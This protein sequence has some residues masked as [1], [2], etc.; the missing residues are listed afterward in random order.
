MHKKLLILLLFNSLKTFGQDL[1]LN[2]NTGLISI[3]DSVEVKKVS[4]SEIKRF[5]SM[6][7]K[8]YFLDK[9]TRENLYKLNHKE[10]SINV[11]GSY[12]ASVSERQRN[13][14]HTSGHLSYYGY[15]RGA[16]TG[17]L[18]SINITSGTV[19]FS[20]LYT[21]KNDKL[22]V[23]EITNFEFVS[24][25]SKGVYG[26]FEDSKPS[27]PFAVGI[28]IKN[29]KIW[30]QIKYDYFERLKI[31]SKGFKEYTHNYFNNSEN[32]TIIQPVKP[33]VNYELYKRI[34]INMN[35]NQVKE[36]FSED[37]KELNTTMVNLNGRSVAQKI[38]VWPESNSSSNRSITVIFHDNKVYS[39]SQ[40]GL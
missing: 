19:S 15:K 9:N 8:K 21:V 28:L 2:P 38:C 12:F 14:F 39:K 37:G 32:S 30:D 22:L 13:L 34:E 29:K 3:I 5:L 6:N 24:I 11:D 4:V 7:W 18:N 20:F 31:M 26:K 25:A 40:T 27:K 17:E 36:I 23:Y 33:L 35:Y 16:I 10:E 1:P